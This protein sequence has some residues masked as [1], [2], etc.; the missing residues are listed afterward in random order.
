MTIVAPTAAPLDVLAA[1]PAPTG[2]AGAAAAFQDV[3]D[4]QG[5]GTGSAPDRGAA[6]PSPDQPALGASQPG[7]VPPTV[8]GVPS[9][10]LAPQPPRLRAAAEAT[11]FPATAETVAAGP[12]AVP[13]QPAAT[14]PS[15]VPAQPAAPPV[16]V[17]TA[18]AAPAVPGEPAAMIPSTPVA[19]S[20][21]AAAAPAVAGRAAAGT[22]Q[23]APAPAPDPAPEL[24][25]G[26]RD[27]D[28]REP[29]AVDAGEQPTAALPGVRRGRPVTPDA[30]A[31]ALGQGSVTL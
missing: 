26:P 22:I 20:G 13:A 6:Q 7:S 15:A 19:P 23:T 1:V 31:T 9:P 17:G 24:D 10:V 3:L 11:L 21:A 2:T 4:R 28:D 14:G 27:G 5:A 25:A 30:D 8:A 12:A 16:D 18:T 29:R